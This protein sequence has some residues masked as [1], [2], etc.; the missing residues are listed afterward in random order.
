MKTLDGSESQAPKAKSLA[1]IM[2]EQA[3]AKP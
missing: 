2:K 3:A 1:E